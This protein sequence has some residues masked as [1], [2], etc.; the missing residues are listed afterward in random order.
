MSKIDIIFVNRILP[1]KKYSIVIGLLQLEAEAIKLFFFQ[2]ILIFSPSH[3][4]SIY[5]DNDSI[6]ASDNNMF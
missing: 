2:L 5:T 1:M 3:S 4:Y 6:R